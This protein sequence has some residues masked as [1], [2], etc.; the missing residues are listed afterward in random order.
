MNDLK[1]MP[2]KSP[3]Y[4]LTILTVIT[5]FLIVAQ[6]YFYDES[7]SM[8]MTKIRK[9]EII[10]TKEDPSFID[11]I[12]FDDNDNDNDNDNDVAYEI[13]SDTSILPPSARIVPKKIFKDKPLVIWAT[14][15]HMTPIKDLK[16]L[17]SPFGVTFLD[18]N[19][20][21]WRC[22]WHDCTAKENLKVG[23]TS[24]IVHKIDVLCDMV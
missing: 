22:E 15:W 4:L 24:K 17:L 20:D 6:L 8:K 21:P 11:R 12:K 7:E 16:N 19:L 9:Y 3:G 14:E 10:Y 2:L 1:K 18:Y 23:L 13:L 5:M